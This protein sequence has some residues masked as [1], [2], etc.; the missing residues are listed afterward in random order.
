MRYELLTESVSY[1]EIRSQPFFDKFDKFRLYHGMRHSLDTPTL[2]PFRFRNKPVDTPEIIH[3]IINIITEERYGLPIR[4][5][6]FLY[7]SA[8]QTRA[9]GT[10]YMIVPKGEFMLYTNPYVYDMTIEYELDYIG[11]DL[12]T[13][14]FKSVYGR[15][16]E[17]VQQYILEELDDEDEDEDDLSNIHEVMDNLEKIS[18]NY[19]DGILKYSSN[20]IS[21]S[22]KNYI[23]ANVYELLDSSIAD[24]IDSILEDIIKSV[25][26][27][28]VKRFATDYVKNIIEVDSDSDGNQPSEF[29]LYAPNGMYVIPENT[30]I[31]N[32]LYRG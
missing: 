2:I 19:H 12:F 22:F 24:Y 16:T 26:T 8:I 32:S 23:K 27:I 15:I 13:N 14:I 1:D 3:N 17:S 7:P 21:A 31:F 29:M 9:Y 5:L 10:P 11:G 25:M 28:H 6:K 20:D 4:N 30:K 18:L